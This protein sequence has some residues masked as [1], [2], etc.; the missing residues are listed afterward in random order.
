MK[1]LTFIIFFLIFAG[2]SSFGQ[3]QKSLENASQEE[4]ELYLNKAEKTK[5]KGA[6]M[7][8]TGSVALVG[9]IALVSSYSNNP[10]TAILTGVLLW[11]AG[12]ITTLIGIPVF[13]TGVSQVNRIKKIKIN[14][15]SE[16]I[17]DLAPCSFRN[18]QTQTQQYGISIRIRL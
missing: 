14:S 12:T 15:N 10:E 17:I 2:L 4:L 11:G 3:N 1:K 16:V 5:K 13:I 6:I 7:S 8:I 9:G 18:Y